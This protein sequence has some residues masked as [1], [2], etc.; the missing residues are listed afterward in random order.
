MSRGHTAHPMEMEPSLLVTPYC[1]QS[2]LILISSTILP[3]LYA[4][5]RQPC[6]ALSAGL[7]AQVH[8]S[9]GLLQPQHSAKTDKRQPSQF[10]YPEN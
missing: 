6:P 7:A 1:R 10:L 9:P 2:F 8:T 3:H 4:Y 5:L